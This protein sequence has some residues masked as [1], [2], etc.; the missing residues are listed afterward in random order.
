MRRFKNLKLY[1]DGITDSYK[2]EKRVESI[3]RAYRWT[4][5]RIEWELDHPVLM[6]YIAAFLI[7]NPLLFGLIISLW[8]K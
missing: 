1:E 6:L 4:C 2:Q 8:R 5:K 3:K 7:L